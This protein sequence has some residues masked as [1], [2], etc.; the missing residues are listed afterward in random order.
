MTAQHSSSDTKVNSLD[1]TSN[2]PKPFLLE[3]AA[4]SL[5]HQDRLELEQNPFYQSLA[6]KSAV[7]GVTEDGKPVIDA[8][9][10][11]FKSINQTLSPIHKSF[12][13]PLND[14]IPSTTLLNKNYVHKK[15]EE[16]VFISE[17]YKVENTTHMFRCTCIINNNH[18]FFF[19]HSMNHVPGL[20]L[21]EAI[22]QMGTA[23]S[24][25]F[26]NVPFGSQFIL[27]DIYSKFYH[28][29]SLDSPTFIDL[30]VTVLKWRNGSAQKLSA[31]GYAYQ[32]GK[33]LCEMTSKWG[34]L[35]QKKN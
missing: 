28:F 11:S 24:H 8:S 19:E 35:S 29:G 1:N 6:D 15:F 3:D 21:L 13:I 12:Q 4:A 32:N 10:L 34:I 9:Q 33:L 5:S 30:P 14:P 18:H 27:Y 25:L 2:E 26:F 20:M 7:V 22:R 23:V 17:P 31:T 16:N